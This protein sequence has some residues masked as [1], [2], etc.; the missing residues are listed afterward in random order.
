MISLKEVIV[1]LTSAAVIGYLPHFL[2]FTLYGWAISSL[3]A[4]LVLTINVLGYKIAARFFDS[5]AELQHWTVSRYGFN[6][7]RTFARPFPIWAFLPVGLVIITFG[8]IKWPW[9][10]VTT[11][12]TSPLILRERRAFS[13]VSEWDTA[14]IAVGG[15]FLSLLAA[16]IGRVG[17]FE[18]FAKLSLWFVFF[19]LI[20]LG[21]LP[22]SKIFFGSKFLWIFSLVFALSVL[23]LFDL[24]TTMGTLAISSILGIGGIVLL[25][26]LIEA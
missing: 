3:I 11:F 16:F 17:G 14:L 5:H 7:S 9:L 23:V 18:E 26:S 6:T 19:N 1:L 25:Y 4:L 13:R 10:A 21:N 2:G 12:E 15:L 22:G 8:A 20:P 24:T